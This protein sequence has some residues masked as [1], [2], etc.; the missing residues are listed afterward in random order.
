[1]TRRNRDR[2]RHVKSLDGTL[3]PSGKS[4]RR[5][6]SSEAEDIIDA[7]RAGQID[8]LVIP[9]SESE[10][11]YAITSF[12]DLEKVD[13]QLKSEG[14][15]RQRSDAARLEVER[16]FETLA[17]HAPVGIYIS[18]GAGNCTF[19]NRCACE[20]IGLSEDDALGQGWTKAVH[21]DDRKEALKQFGE[22]ASTDQVVDAEFRFLHQDGKTVWVAARTIKI[23]RDEGTVTGTIGTITDITVHRL[24][25]LALQ[26]ASERLQVVLDA[27]P[28]AIISV[29]R[30]GRI[31]AW[32]QG[33]ERM[34]GWS[35]K[36]VLGRINPTVPDGE[37]GE[38]HEKIDRVLAGGTFKGQL[39]HR[40]TKSGNLI[41]AVISARPLPD[42]SAVNSGIV[43]IVD[44]ITE[45]ERAN[46][47]LRALA[48]ERERFFQDMHDGCIQSIYAVGLNLEV[49]RPL[50]GVDPTK[51]AQII[52]AAAANLDLVIQDLRSF[53]GDKQ[54][55]PAG[56]KLRAE[57]ARAV[58]AAGE[59]GLAFTLDIDAAAEDA[60]IPEQA[61]E[62]LQIAREAISNANRHAKA[63]R[64]QLSL[65]IRDEAVC[66]EVTDDGIGFNPA[67]PKKRGLGLH[68]MDARAR[69]LGGQ[70]R[71]VS[72]PKHGTRVVVEIPLKR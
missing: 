40:K 32:S 35:E 45:Q 31:I 15:A 14:S 67:A 60:L 3:A 69:K 52:A 4:A 65:Q 33:A 50:I 41:Q 12:A 61:F 44:D 21:A 37:M 17:M 24:A 53:M 68:H 70:A 63:R 30:T 5:A 8:A 19:F 23:Q 29:D 47:Q 28:V 18:D 16:R 11:L 25:E 9:G 55:L 59:S 43:L 38:F 71:V 46:E 2:D 48:D 1:V 36:E 58:Q 49:C 13:S 26:E 39:R 42:R 72:A 10:N 64:G 27:S 57:I 56:R 66:F 20:I 51:V 6:L 62:L 34:F 22:A 7:I 54:H